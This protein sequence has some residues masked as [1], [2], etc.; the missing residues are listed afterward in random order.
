MAVV[1]SIVDIVVNDER[2]KAFAASFDKYQAALKKS[3]LQWTNVEKATAAAALATKETTE[4]LEKQREELERIEKQRQEA[5][6]KEQE[7][8][9]KQWEKTKKYLSE[10]KQAV[11]SLAKTVVGGA[12]QIAEGLG[13]GTI[14]SGLMGAG[15]LFGLDRLAQSVGDQRR[16]AQGLGTTSGQQNA[17]RLNF[18]RYFDTD[19]V[20]ENIADAKS[21]LGKQ[22][23]FTAMGVNPN[24]KDPAQLA[25]EMALKAKDIIGQ[26]PITTQFAQAHQL[27]KF[28]SMEDLR[29]LQASSYEDIRKSTTAYGKDAKLTISDADQK[30]F[31]DF[32]QEL[33]RAKL[34]IEMAF[35]DG[36]TPI[37][38]QLRQL[39]ASVAD[40]IKTFISNPHFKD[41]MKQ[42]GEG[43]QVVADYLGSDKFQKDVTTFTTDFALVAEAVANGLK[44]LGIIPQ[45]D[46][47]AKSAVDTANAQIKDNGLGDANFY[48]SSFGSSDKQKAQG[49][50][51]FMSQGWS[52]AQAAGIVANLDKESGL[53]AGK[54]GDNGKAYGLAQWHK[55][56][57]D[58][59]KKWSGH[60]IQHSSLAEQ[61][62]FVNQELTKGAFKD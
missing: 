5:H 15:G 16:R 3:G 40:T 59:F 56:R 57:Q 62:A 37:I 41:W 39:S 11:T 12:A 7:R 9:R 49:I 25:V 45:G 55:D 61:Y 31:Q 14:L 50:K 29:R 51:Y 4:E 47:T 10:E 33:D 34:K 24:G 18:Q 46:P 1:K 58:A 21:D 8:R 52:A 28:F 26:G 19:S 2:F 42:F 44:M 23:A 48:S 17:L 27:D 6:E 32:A 54:F 20:L 36:L 22:Y 43:L 60:D 35:V 53:T 30:K 38:P 13:V